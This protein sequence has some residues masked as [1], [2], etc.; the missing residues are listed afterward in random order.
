VCILQLLE[1]KKS[2]ALDGATGAANSN[3]YS[4]LQPRSFLQYK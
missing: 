4:M 1:E 2:K 3:N